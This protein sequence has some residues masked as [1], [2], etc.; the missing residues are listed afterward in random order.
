MRVLVVTNMFP[1]TETPYYGIFV[2]EQIKAIEKRFPEVKYD[3]YFI[4]GRKGMK[5]YLRSI[6]GVNKKIRKGKYDIVHI[7]YGLSGMFLLSPMRTYVPTLLTLH[8]SDIMPKS[9]TG[10][11]C[12]YISHKAVE[13][14]DMVITLNEE[15]DG[16]VKKMNPHSF[17]IPCSVDTD[18]F[19]PLYRKVNDGK[20]HI[21][22]SS[23]RERKVKDYPLFKSTVQVLQDKYGIDCVEHELKNLTRKQV[24]QLYSDS[25]I[26]LMTSIS[27]G[28]PQVVKEAM[29]CNLPCVSTNVGDVEVLLSGVKDSYVAKTRDAE[30]LAML[31]NKSLSHDG[32][33]MSGREKIFKL[34]INEDAVSEMIY[35]L[36]KELVIKK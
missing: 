6:W 31:V 17:I 21:V 13:L 33:G 9:G 30:E 14:S 22:F 23:N 24:S 12:H 5:E 11:L 35:S 4:D 19:K 3:I 26:L 10:F 2:S 25:D 8:G 28:S 32:N 27:E 20:V 16:I 36:Y 15:M 18:L 7:H 1:T 34:K 29:A